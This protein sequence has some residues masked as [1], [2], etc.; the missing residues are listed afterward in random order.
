MESV[1]VERVLT[2]DENDITR[3]TDL[4][5]A[6]GRGAVGVWAGSTQSD[7]L[8]S[9]R[10]ANQALSTRNPV[11]YRGATVAI[12]ENNEAPMATKTVRKGDPIKI[13]VDV[14]TAGTTRV[15]TIWMGQLS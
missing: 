6:P 1:R 9:I 14:V 10:V 13:D 12:N 7:H 11:P 4:A 3:D 2:A 8:I 15:T 5:Q